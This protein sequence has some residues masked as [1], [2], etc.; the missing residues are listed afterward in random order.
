M[1]IFDISRA[2]SPEIA[3]WPGDQRFE[4]SWSARI[5]EGAAVNVGAVRLSTHTGTHADAPY[6]YLDDGADITALPLEK[7]IGPALVVEVPVTDAIR[8]EHLENLDFSRVRRILFKTK[9][10][11][12]DDSVW[13]D[14][15]VYLSEEAAAM[16]GRRGVL[17]VGMD[18]PSVDPVDSKT[19]AA[20]KVLAQY[21][22]VN[23]ENLKLAGVPPGEYELIALPL[24]LQGLD[25]SP[26]R[27]VLVQRD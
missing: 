16:V 9:S 23:L 8:P 7:Y 17:L 3:V 4:P 6:H 21:G 5:A 12:L 10:S 15:I 26:V 25:A 19:L 24:K 1:R 18:G 2:L 11:A 20:H 13:I 27:A 22:V 14:D